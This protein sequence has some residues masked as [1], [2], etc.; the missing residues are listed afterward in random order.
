MSRSAVVTGGASGIGLATVHRLHRDGWHVVAADR[1]AAALAE[2]PADDRI[3]PVTADVTDEEQAGRV[4]AVADELGEG[5]GAVVTCA[6]VVRNAAATETSVADFRLSLEVNLTGTFLVCRAAARRMLRRGDGGSLVTISSVSGLRGG[7]QRAAYAASKAGVTALTQVLAAE[8]G[9]AGIRVN[10]VAP[11]A[12]D[13]P[14]VKVAQPPAVRDA[15]LAA[16]PLGRYARAEEIAAVIAFLA[17]GESAFVTGQTWC[18]D[19]GQTAGPGWRTR[20]DS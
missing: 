10:C 19:G 6:G 13:T 2:L 16:I 17:G 15:V 12:T 1:D 3:V 8:L 4:V 20:E 9:P 7:E 18:V 5:L 14:L 11:G